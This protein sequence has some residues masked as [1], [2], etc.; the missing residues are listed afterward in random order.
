MMQAIMRKELKKLLKQP[1]T[2]F[3]MVGF[4]IIFIVIFASVFGNTNFTFKVY[5]ADYDKSTMSKEF[6]EQI[7]TSKS[8]KFIEIEEGEDSIEKVKDGTYAVYIEIPKG[9][10]EKVTNQQEVKILFAYDGTSGSAQAVEPVRTLFESVANEYKEQK[11]KSA[12]LSFTKD[13][14]I[15]TQ[16]MTSPL[17]IQYEAQETKKVNAITQYIPGYTVMAVFFIMMS[18]S[19]VFLDDKKNGMVTRLASTPIKPIHYLLGMWIPNIILVCGQIAV[20]FAFG[21]FVY[22]LQIGNIPALIVL[23]FVLALVSTSM[24]LVVSF[25]SKDDNTAQ[26]FAQIIAIGG[27]ALGG[28]WFPLSI[29]PEFMQSIAQFLPQY[30]AQ[31]AYIDIFA[32]DAN[33][34]AIF[35]AIAILLAFTL[36]SVLLALITYKR[37][38]KGAA[39]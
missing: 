5:Y 4:P 20:L 2:Y 19:K 8:F 38:Y 7:S 21:H 34:V 37:F 1:G 32:R 18:M 35:P 26:A 33:I 31:N 6:I 28:L 12:L 13:E 24:G 14:A 22:D 17:H 29:M 36:I 16:L 39:S 15:T 9:F 11:V 27:A 25:I 23:S 10:E 3:W 30:W